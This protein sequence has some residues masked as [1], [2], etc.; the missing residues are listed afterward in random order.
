VLDRAILPPPKLHHIPSI[1]LHAYYV[2]LE[3]REAAECEED[4]II[5]G[6]S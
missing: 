6:F 2:N 3:A 5:S 4:I 1:L